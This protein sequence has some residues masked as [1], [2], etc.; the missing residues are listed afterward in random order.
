MTTPIRLTLIALAHVAFLV[1]VYGTRIFLI[2]SI[3]TFIGQTI[4]F[5]GST[6]GAGVAYW[7]FGQNMKSLASFPRGAIFAVVASLAS[8]GLGVFLAFNLFGT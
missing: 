1:G 6:T 7:Y 3:P 8:L 5:I 2:L 4:Y